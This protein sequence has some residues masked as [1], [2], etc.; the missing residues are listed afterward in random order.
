MHIDDRTKTPIIFTCLIL[1]LVI[2]LI[3]VPKNPPLTPEEQAH[4][5]DRAANHPTCFK[6]G[7]LIQC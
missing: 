6:I 2:G 3:M 7:F 1:F 5:E 4:K